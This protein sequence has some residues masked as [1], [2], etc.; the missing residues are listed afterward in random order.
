MAKERVT[1]AQLAAD[2]SNL[3]KARAAKGQ[4]GKHRHFRLLGY[5]QTIVHKHKPIAIG[6]ARARSVTRNDY[7]RPFG[8]RVLGT[9][10]ISYRRKVKLTVR[11]PT[12]VVKKFQREIAPGSYYKRT[13]WCAARKHRMKKNVHSRRPRFQRLGKWRMRR[14]RYTPR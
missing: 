2:R 3:A 13:G 11:R 10:L 12:G 7:L 14:K 9:R 8:K 4:R 6:A 5:P 1:A